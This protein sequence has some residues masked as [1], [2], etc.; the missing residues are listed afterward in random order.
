MKGF[1]FFPASLTG[2]L[3]KLL[4]TCFWWGGLV[5]LSGCISLGSAPANSWSSQDRSRMAGALRLETVS[6]DKAVDKAS[7]ER[8]IRGRAPLIFLKQGYLPA[9]EG[10]DPGYRADIR[11]I[12]R[13]YISGWKTRRSLSMEVLIWQDQGELRDPVPLASGRAAG[14]GQ[15]SLSSSPVLDRLLKTAVKRALRALKK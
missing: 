2:F 14:A 1:S 13:E 12:E 11:A 3:K 5:F 15:A 9:A 4:L 6:V 8:E 7:V 10:E